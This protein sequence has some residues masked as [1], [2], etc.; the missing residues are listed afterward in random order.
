VF[1]VF[2]DT[3]AIY[4]AGLSDLLLSLAER[5][6]Y[7]PLW[8]ADVL[9]ELHDALC[10]NGINP[11]AVE[12]RIGAM[13]EA[14]PDA[15][16][17]GYKHLVPRMDCDEGDRHV[18]A[19]AVRGGAS[20]IV[21]FNLRHFPQAALD[22]Y[23]ISVTSPDEFLLDQLD[24]YPALTVQ[25]VIDVLGLYENPPITVD[26]FCNLLRRSGVPKF[27]TAITHLL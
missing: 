25:T 4:G 18:L 10:R 15:E 2:L 22:S 17:F 13:R 7:R 23:Q 12:R 11:T 3:N 27:V 26:E 1:P 16:V 20:I 19:A 9:N 14:F 6:T 5:G 24:L 8:S 21:T